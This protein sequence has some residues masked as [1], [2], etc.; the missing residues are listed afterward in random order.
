[1]TLSDTLRNWIDEKVTANYDYSLASSRKADLDNFILANKER[2]WKSKSVRPSF[3]RIL[4]EVLKNKGINPKSLGRQVKKPKYGGNIES[5]ITPKPV[6]GEPP[7][8]NSSPQVATETL[9]ITTLTIQDI[10]SDML[11]LTDSSR[12][13]ATITDSLQ[14]LEDGTQLM[15]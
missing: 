6:A 11:E 14:K 4:D 7:K 12:K 15:S 2:G 8:E 3:H 9:E 13:N 5:E 1:M 10:S